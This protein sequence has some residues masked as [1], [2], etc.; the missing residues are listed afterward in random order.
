MS[1]DEDTVTELVP[2]NQP[3]TMW[4]FKSASPLVYPP[5]GE[6]ELQLLL[7]VAF[8]IQPGLEQSDLERMVFNPQ[9]T[10]TNG[11]YLPDGRRLYRLAHPQHQK[12][13]YRE[14]DNEEILYM[15]WKSSTSLFG[16]APPY[17]VETPT[18]FGEAGQGKSEHSVTACIDWLCPTND[19]KV[20]ADPNKVQPLWEKTR[21]YLKLWNKQWPLTAEIRIP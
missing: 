2:W 11:R 12:T 6:H 15:E 20:V 7:R 13:E 14:E 17:C 18:G 19:R 3:E 4:F 16:L 8:L 1:T 21:L 10:I 5:D 9:I